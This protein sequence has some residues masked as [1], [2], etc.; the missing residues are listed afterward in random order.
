MDIG[1]HELLNIVEMIIIIGAAGLAPSMIKPS[2]V[3]GPFIL[4]PFIRLYL[5]VS[6]GAPH[7]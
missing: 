7:C 6:D 1:I 5:L 4:C 2:K 3:G